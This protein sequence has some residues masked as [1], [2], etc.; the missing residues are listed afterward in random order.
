VSTAHN[1]LL[2]PS[3]VK[4]KSDI[5]SLACTGQVV[6]LCTELWCAIISLF[7]P[8]GSGIHCVF[9]TE[10]VSY[11]VRFIHTHLTMSGQSY[12]RHMAMSVVAHFYRIQ[13]INMC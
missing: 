10:T 3:G 8:T 13:N 1:S 9:L 12:L 7:S 2:F 11:R 5:L 4:S 6:I